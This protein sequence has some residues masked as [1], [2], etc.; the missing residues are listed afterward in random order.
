MAHF[1]EYLQQMVE[2]F[3][4][5]RCTTYAARVE[6]QIGGRDGHQALDVRAQPDHAT[7]TEVRFIGNANERQGAP[8]QG[9]AGIDDG[10]GLLGRE[11]ATERGMVLVEVSRRRSGR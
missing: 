9:M 2:S 11:W 5:E 3:E 8:A 4:A 7:T 6:L 1:L 10:D